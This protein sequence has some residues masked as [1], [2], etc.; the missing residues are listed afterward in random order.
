MR[1]ENPSVNRGGIAAAAEGG[2]GG[3]SWNA[4][5]AR[6]TDNQSPL[7][8]CDEWVAYELGCTRSDN[9]I[10]RKK[11]RTGHVRGLR[12]ASRSII[13]QAATIYTQ[14][15]ITHRSRSIV[16]EESPRRE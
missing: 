8:I 5:F 9:R 11:E 14:V 1:F 12:Y 7:V 3:G 4:K 2:G 6:V 16:R 10:K 13:F 15:Y